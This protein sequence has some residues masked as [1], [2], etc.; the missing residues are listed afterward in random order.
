MMAMPMALFLIGIM[1]ATGHNHRRNHQK[2]S[3]VSPPNDK[4][5]SSH[6]LKDRDR[7]SKVTNIHATLDSCPAHGAPVHF[8]PAGRERSNLG[9][10]SFIAGSNRVSSIE[11]HSHASA[12][13]RELP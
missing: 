3:R 8:Q 5:S 1:G 13:L 11:N 9:I 7:G 10:H 4:D 2:R 12:Y 6:A